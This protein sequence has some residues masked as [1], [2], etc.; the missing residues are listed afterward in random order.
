M[1]G[2]VIKRK[3]Q[4]ENE[5][6]IGLSLKKTY[7]TPA[8]VQEVVE[9]VNQK[10]AYHRLRNLGVDRKGAFEFDINVSIPK[11]RMCLHS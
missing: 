6:G 8:V 5:K 4:K 3:K 11:L 7:K 9:I 2:H 1:N 10:K